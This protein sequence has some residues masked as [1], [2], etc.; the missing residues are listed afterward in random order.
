MR[1]RPAGSLGRRLARWLAFL[2]L[3]GL[4]L[5]CLGVYTVTALSFKERQMDTLRQKQLQ[6]SHLIAEAGE[7]DNDT[8]THKLN[9]AMVG[10]QDV[11]VILSGADGSVLYASS[12]VPMD[13]RTID[14]RFEA[15]NGT[16]DK[17]VY[18]ASDLLYHL[19]VLL[20]SKGL[21]IEDIARELAKRHNPDWDKAR[22]I[23]KSKE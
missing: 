13:H 20:A 16:N 7:L 8:L 11:M 12:A 21:R 2:T 3:A 17:L 5:I 1:L 23:K 14:M 10:Q 19:V 15:T 9:D 22:R 18:E 4:A 6:V